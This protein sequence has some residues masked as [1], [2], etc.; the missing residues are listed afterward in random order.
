MP[1]VMTL[2]RDAL[3]S[4]LLDLVHNVVTLQTH[5][6]A[7]ERRQPEATG[8]FSWILSA[9]SISAKMIAAKIRRARHRERPRRGRAARRGT[10]S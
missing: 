10:R 9:G 8:S 5:I 1:G 6:L 7:E 3:E 2:E 4:P